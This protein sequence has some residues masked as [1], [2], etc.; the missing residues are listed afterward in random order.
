[1]YPICGTEET[2]REM[3]SSRKKLNRL[4]FSRNSITLLRTGAQRENRVLNRIKKCLLLGRNRKFL[5]LFYSSPLTGIE[6]WKNKIY[7]I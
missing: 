2:L 1:M 6:I 5:I 7:E 4:T 3:L